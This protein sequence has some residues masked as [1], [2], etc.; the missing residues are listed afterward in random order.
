M[1]PLVVDPFTGKEFTLSG[2]AFG[3]AVVTYLLDSA[4][5]DPALIEGSV[6]MVANGMQIVPSSS[7]RFQKDKQPVVYM[8]VYNPL[9]ASGNLSMGFLY[10]IVD[11]KTNQ[12]VHTSNTIPINHYIRP[13]NPRIPVIFNLLI[14][15]LPAGDYRLETW[16]RD[17]AGNVSPLRTGDFSIQ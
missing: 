3:D 12:K 7:N 10:D 8:E 13:G 17:S 11:R 9:L 1:V 5:M 6:P 14:D 15:K 16:A 2:P 4:E